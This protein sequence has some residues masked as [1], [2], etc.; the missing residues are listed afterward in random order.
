[1]SS[2]WLA[3]VTN[4]STY[5]SVSVLARGKPTD[6]KTNPNKMKNGIIVK[7]AKVPFQK[8]GVHYVPPSF[9]SLNFLK[10]S[11]LLSIRIFTLM[12]N[13]GSFSSYVMVHEKP[14]KNHCS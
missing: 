2:L 7:P 10:T 1:M 14:N 8:G 6:L 4:S 12:F 13:S 9:F 5:T 11:L 3:S